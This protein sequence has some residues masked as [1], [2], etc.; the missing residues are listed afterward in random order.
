M[1]NA[2]MTSLTE[3]QQRMDFAK[4]AAAHFAAHPEHWTYCD[5]ELG[6]NVLLALRWGLGDDCVLVVRIADELPVNFQ[7][8]IKRP[9]P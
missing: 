7:N 6:A 9:T 5:E 8:I 3:E 2:R 1:T 4:T